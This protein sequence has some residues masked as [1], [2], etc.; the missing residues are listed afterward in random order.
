MVAPWRSSSLTTTRLS[1]STAWWSAVMP[2][3]F[4][5]LMSMLM[6]ALRSIVMMASP[7]DSL[8]LSSNMI[9]SGNL[10][11]RSP[12]CCRAKKEARRDIV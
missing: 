8:M 9:S 6:L 11:L 1:S 12:G 4:T 10:T 7:S 2:A 3:V 5:R